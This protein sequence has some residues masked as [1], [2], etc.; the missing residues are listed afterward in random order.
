MRL[1]AKKTTQCCGDGWI[2]NRGW[3]KLLKRVVDTQHNNN[4]WMVR[5]SEATED[6]KEGCAELLVEIRKSDA[7]HYA[8]WAHFDAAMKGPS[9]QANQWLYEQL[10]YFLSY[11]CE[12]AEACAG[13]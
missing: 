9:E 4:R 2:A 3:Y 1:Q 10:Q 13:E 12:S 11:G 6:K 5:C 7:A 8:D